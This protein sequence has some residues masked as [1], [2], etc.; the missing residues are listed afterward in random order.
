[1]NAEQVSSLVEQIK[2]ANASSL[3]AVEAKLDAKLGELRKEFQLDQKEVVQQ[4]A[5]KARKEKPLEFRS[6][7]NKAQYHFNESVADAFGEVSTELSKLEAVAG[8][9]PS[10][11][12]TATKM[13][14]ALKAARDAIEEG[15]KL[16]GKRQKHIK[17]A[18]RSELGWRVV[19]EYET[20]ELASDSA[21][22]KRM[23]DAEKAA[24]KKVSAI[25]KKRKATAQLSRPSSVSKPF[26][27]RPPSHRAQY[28]GPR[29]PVQTP[30]SAIKPL[31]PTRAPAIGPCFGCNEFGHLRSSCPKMLQQYPFDKSA[32]SIVAESSMPS[33][34]KAVLH[35]GEME[36]HTDYMSQIACL[37]KSESS[38]TTE[39]CD[40]YWEI[41][42]GS[43]NVKGRLKEC[44]DYW[45]DALSASEPILQ[46]IRH[47]YILPLMSK[48]EK[49]MGANHKSALLNGQFV[50]KAIAD[51]LDKGC[52]KLVHSIPHICSP[53]L[54]LKAAVVKRG[55]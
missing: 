55:W 6:K 18:D 22:E 40:R 11:S 16:I 45:S 3:A 52:V 5:K 48:P 30:T 33:T 2:A 10:T 39:F 4:V 51:L 42:S 32:C 43:D 46:M 7:G 8:G 49:W 35:E 47:G 20:D 9:L 13:S 14:G 41:D 28:W 50:D 53:L 21:D 12:D 15:E 24:E 36:K 29:A 37:D 31:F 1:M 23:A 25:G 19:K 17:L 34:S 54:V 27:Y 44:I 38:Y 26:L